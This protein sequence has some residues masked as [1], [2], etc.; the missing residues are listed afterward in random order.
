MT[1]NLKAHTLRALA[2]FSCASQALRPPVDMTMMPISFDAGRQNL[3]I[4]LEVG[5]WMLRIVGERER[6]RERRKGF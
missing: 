3:V 1:S 4:S 5:E 6:E 2:S